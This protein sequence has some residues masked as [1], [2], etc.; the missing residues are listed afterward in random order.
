MY[1]FYLLVHTSIFY[2][3]VYFQGLFVPLLWLI[4]VLI[5]IA[6]SCLPNSKSVFLVHFSFYSRMLL[7]LGS[8]GLMSDNCLQI[9]GCLILHNAGGLPALRHHIV[10]CKSSLLVTTRLEWHHC[11]VLLVHFNLVGFHSKPCFR[12]NWIRSIPYL[13]LSFCLRMKCSEPNFYLV[14]RTKLIWQLASSYAS[15]AAGL[16]SCRT[17]SISIFL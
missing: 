7:S 6:S 12:S 5:L 17:L 10:S 14:L 3:W 2:C 8:C 16:F 9:Y 13:H 15:A 4:C 11:F 1:L